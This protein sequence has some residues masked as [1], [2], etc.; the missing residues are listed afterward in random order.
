MDNKNIN[1]IE[2][3][4]LNTIFC[5]YILS[6]VLPI[7][8][9]FNIPVQKICIC[10]FLA[11]SGYIFIKL[12]DW[13]SIIRTSKLEIVVLISGALWCVV[14]WLQGCEYSVE[15]ASLLYLSFIM[16][17][18][19][20]HLIKENLLDLHKIMRCLFWMMLAKIIAKIILEV[21][22]LCKLI[23][24]EVLYQLYIQ[25]FNVE[26]IMMTMKLGSLTF[27]RVQSTS[28]ILVI[29]LLPFFLLLPEIRRSKK[30]WLTVLLA[31]Y[32]MIVYSRLYMVEFASFMVLLL[33]F[34]WKYISKKVRY[35]G[36]G[37]AV[38]TSFI[39]FK[40]IFKIVQYRFFS[41]KVVESDSVRQLQ[42]QELTKGISEAPLFGHGMG[43]YLPNLI[44]ST[45][46]PFSYEAEYLS[47][48][49]QF[50]L[51]GFV[52]IILGIISVYIKEIWQ[53]VKYNNIQIKL[54]TLLCLAWMLARP[55]FNPSFYGIQNGFYVIGLLLINA[56]FNIENNNSKMVQVQDNLGAQIR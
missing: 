11:V 17:L 50:G 2:K 48:L 42:I 32:T 12:N 41:A 49:Y 4:W 28:D 46:A 1:T 22:F 47:F 35:I 27:V 44:R 40:P 33:L 45:T 21:I 15:C 26:A 10:L 19:I 34:E 37:G 39:W 7:G 8:K 14:S 56:Y 43:S 9:I 55:I 51:I 18:I 5:L 23:Q 6:Y 16:F 13:K 25:I 20:L 52:M 36:I 24:Y 31:I 3:N 38:L 29:G 53:Y 30:F 54:F